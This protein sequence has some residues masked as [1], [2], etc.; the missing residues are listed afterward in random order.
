MKSFE[1][2][3]GPIGNEEISS[4]IEWQK[5]D[6]KLGAQAFFL[7]QVRADVVNGS[8]VASIEYESYKEMVESRVHQLIDQGSQK[9]HLTHVL[10]RHSLGP[11][12]VGGIG[13]LIAVSSPHRNGSFAG[14]EFLVNAFKAEIPIFG[15]E[16][17]ENGGRAVKRNR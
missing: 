2:I 1:F 6:D 8:K 15:T 14:L 11:V 7:G 17:L 3:E 13:F 16:I 12:E 9:F 5:S 10:I 4:L